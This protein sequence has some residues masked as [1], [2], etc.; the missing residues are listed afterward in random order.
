MY[1]LSVKAP[2]GNKRVTVAFWQASDDS[3][4]ARADR[5]FKE[6]GF[7]ELMGV[8]QTYVH[9]TGDLRLQKNWAGLHPQCKFFDSAG[10]EITNAEHMAMLPKVVI[11]AL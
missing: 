10:Q 3:C 8:A 6:H 7:L 5:F 9:W 2:K 11:D 4:L 1:D